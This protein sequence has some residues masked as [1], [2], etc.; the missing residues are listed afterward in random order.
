MI[1]SSIP[2]EERQA[3]P[4]GAPRKRRILLDISLFTD[5][6]LDEYALGQYSS[7]MV[8]EVPAALATMIQLAGKDPERSLLAELLYGYLQ[9][10]SQAK[11][12][13]VNRTQSTA[14]SKNDASQTHEALRKQARDL[15]RTVVNVY[16]PLIQGVETAATAARSESLPGGPTREAGTTARPIGQYAAFNPAAEPVKEALQ[17]AYQD[18]LGLMAEPLFNLYFLQVYHGER[19]GMAASPATPRWVVSMGASTFEILCRAFG[20]SSSYSQRQAIQLSHDLEPTTQ[21]AVAF[22]REFA[23]VYLKEHW[24]EAALTGALDLAVGLI[25]VSVSPL[26]PILITLGGGLLIGAVHETG[27]IPAAAK[28][29]IFGGIIVAGVL[30]LFLL[31]V[32]VGRP[33][34]ETPVARSLTIKYEFVRGAVATPTTDP[35]CLISKPR[36]PTPARI[37]TPVAPR[38]IPEPFDRR[39]LPVPPPPSE[40]FRV[41]PA[42]PLEMTTVVPIPVVVWAIPWSVDVQPVTVDADAWAGGSPSGLPYVGSGGDDDVCYYV[43][44]PGDTVQGV[45]ARFAIPAESIRDAQGRAVT[46][47][48]PRQMLVVPA[49]CCRP[50]GGQG[51]TYVVQGGDRL[52]RLAMTYGTT[53][54]GIVSANGLHDA[55]YIQAGQMLCIPRW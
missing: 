28:P 7:E 40:L 18:E 41:E 9:V 44:Q 29:W 13:E 12:Q 14:A 11:A 27:L 42:T 25:P 36:P 38:T 10:R 8:L 35:L 55:S 46:F 30:L 1:N 17:Q 15:A 37:A 39:H 21:P 3:T 16:A 49:S 20:Y 2:S 32:L 54:Q 26:M 50:I 19:F 4:D 31:S 45:A 33:K 51:S 53:V 5:T 48:Q 34:N 22:L 47:L 6:Y 24:K 52:Y 23:R 43:A